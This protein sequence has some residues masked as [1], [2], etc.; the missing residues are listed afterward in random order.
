[1]GLL[2]L[3]QLRQLRI[4]QVLL[5]SWVVTLL[6]IFGWR[7]SNIYIVDGI[8]ALI[9]SRAY[10]QASIVTSTCCVHKAK[11]RDGNDF[12]TK[13]NNFVRQAERNHADY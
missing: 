3:S 9:S 8:S 2:K 1:M 4:L 13:Y 10:G 12:R 5:C 7:E 11:S 6:I